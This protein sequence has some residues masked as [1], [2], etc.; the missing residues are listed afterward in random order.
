M[1]KQTISQLKTDN[2]KITE[3][4]NG[5]NMLNGKL[6][7]CYARA[8][9]TALMNAVKMN[10]EILRFAGERFQA[11][12]HALQT[13]SRCTNWTEFTDCQTDFARTVTEAYETEVSRLMT[14]GTD[15]TNATLKPLQDAVETAAKE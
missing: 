3:P 13:M 4:L 5:M 1:A 10:Q 12:V 7:A 14:M 11:D 8:G 15:A 6:M 9:Q 2:A